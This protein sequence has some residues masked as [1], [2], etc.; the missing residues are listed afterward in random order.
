MLFNA[1]DGGSAIDAHI[2]NFGVA[3]SILDLPGAD[4]PGLGTGAHASGPSQNVFTF[5]S[6]ALATAYAGSKAA[7][8]LAKDGSST[9]V[10]YYNPH[11]PGYGGQSHAYQIATIAGS[12]ASPGNVA[13]HITFANPLIHPAHVA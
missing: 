7:I 8:L 1:A 4:F 12:G 6:D 10:Y 11:D 2:T 13:S 3:N 5:A 9:D